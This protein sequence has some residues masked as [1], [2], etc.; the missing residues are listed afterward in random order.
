MDPRQRFS[1]LV[2]F[3]WNFKSPTGYS[4]LVVS[5]FAKNNT[6][7]AAND[8]GILFIGSSS[9]HDDADLKATRVAKEAF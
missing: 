2:L 9:H 4:K 6:K 3:S 1:L 5:I 8:F 7:V